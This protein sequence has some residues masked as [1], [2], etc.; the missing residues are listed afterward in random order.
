MVSPACASTSVLEGRA[1]V[2]E[3]RWRTQAA[4]LWEPL[5]PVAHRLALTSLSYHPQTAKRDF[6]KGLEAKYQA[7][8]EREGVFHVDAPS[9]QD[10]PFGTDPNEIR[11]VHPKFMN[12]FPFPYQNGRLHLGHA[13]SFS[14]CEFATG[15]EALVLKREIEMFGSMF[16]C[17]D[18]IEDM[19]KLN[20]KEGSPAPPAHKH[21]K[22]AAK[23][24][25]S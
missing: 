21:S 17:T 12:T 8:W 2:R 14:K 16:D 25:K 22:V 19:S 6:L 3:G 5:F 10:F 9:L 20:I 15:G 23:S 4:S 18:G 7:E 11:K 13:F 1:R 24:G